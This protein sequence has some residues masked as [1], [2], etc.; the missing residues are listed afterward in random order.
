MKQ[1]LALLV[2][3][4]LVLAPAAASAAPGTCPMK[5]DRTMPSMRAGAASSSSAPCCKH[6]ACM[7]L[8]MSA[9]QIVATPASLPWAASVTTR[10]AGWS[11]ALAPDWPSASLVAEK[12]PPK[13]GA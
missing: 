5:C 12:P 7:A 6:K 4:A 3:F 8:C 1:L 2:A 11:M 10:S 13:R 9:G